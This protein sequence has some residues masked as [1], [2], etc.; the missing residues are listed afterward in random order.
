LADGTASE[1][2]TRLAIPSHA[3]SSNGHA[4]TA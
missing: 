3:K 1:E 4:E 2:G